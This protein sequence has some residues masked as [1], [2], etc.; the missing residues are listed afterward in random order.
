MENVKE[1]GCKWP[2]KPQQKRTKA[3][4]SD[5][6]NSKR[7][8]K[9]TKIQINKKTKDKVKGKCCNLKIIGNE[10][11]TDNERYL[12]DGE[13]VFIADD[14]YFNSTNSVYQEKFQD[15]QMNVN[16]YNRTETAA[17]NCCLESL[18]TDNSNSRD[19]VA[20][21]SENSKQPLDHNSNKLKKSPNL[22]TEVCKKSKKTQHCPKE[23]CSL[24]S[25]SKNSS[26]KR[27][28]K[29]N[30]SNMC[31]TNALESIRVLKIKGAEKS[32]N[33][34]IQNALQCYS[35]N[36]YISRDLLTKIN[37]NFEQNPS[38]STSNSPGL[39]TNNISANLETTELS[40]KQTT[41][42]KI[43]NYLNL[44]K[45]AKENSQTTTKQNSTKSNEEIIRDSSK[46][47]LLYNNQQQPVPNYKEPNEIPTINSNNVPP[48][49]KETL[50]L[51][52][53]QTSLESTT[54]P[55][56]P[57]LTQADFEN[58]LLYLPIDSYLNRA[59]TAVADF[60]NTVK[61]SMSQ[62]YESSPIDKAI[63]N[64]LISL[65]NCVE[66]FSKYL[67]QSYN[68]MELMDAKTNNC[69]AYLKSQNMKNMR[70]QNQQLRNRIF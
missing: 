55:N 9:A 18:N 25:T 61:S 26:N 2:G 54:I 50:K 47:Q 34:S 1:N 63:H 12:T 10:N 7:L 69:V 32:P 67:L 13:L 43:R 41:C 36:V 21:S 19:I 53:K 17:T 23:C 40:S 31:R 46:F 60:Q 45:P 51:P 48:N 37:E 44:Q 49:N 64:D 39:Q 16:D 62:I 24:E 5:K 68:D 70:I 6:N 28:S 59:T 56:S 42:E 35:E 57:Y 65:D 20:R 27:V 22:E 15:F 3:D 30:A 33:L 11:S 29:K 58:P 38:Q 52:A 8:K 4:K 66:S 14:L